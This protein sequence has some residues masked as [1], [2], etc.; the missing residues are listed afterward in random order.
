M[1]GVG[2]RR[3]V[4]SGSGVWLRMS[5]TDPARILHPAAPP[6]SAASVASL[7]RSQQG[8][9]ATGDCPCGPGDPRDVAWP[10]HLFS[11]TPC[12]HVPSRSFA[13]GEGFSRFSSAEACPVRR[14]LG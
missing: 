13:G 6:F 4:L 7:S 14:E 2:R 12:T 3:W 1:S 8:G 9:D 11:I 5:W 10:G